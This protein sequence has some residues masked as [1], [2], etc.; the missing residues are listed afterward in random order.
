MN[1]STTMFFEWYDV[2]RMVRA[3]VDLAEHIKVKVLLN[4]CWRYIE[5]SGG[6]DATVHSCEFISLFRLIMLYGNRVGLEYLG[7]NCFRYYV[8]TTD[9]DEAEK[10]KIWTILNITDGYE[11]EMVTLEFLQDI[12]CDT[13]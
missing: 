7:T 8:I 10:N 4:E 3:C 9:L 1:H 12:G 5:K 13:F 6:R 11:S 2:I